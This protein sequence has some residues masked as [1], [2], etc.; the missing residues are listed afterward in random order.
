[1]ENKYQHWFQF[2]YWRWW[3]REPL[4]LLGL[5]VMAHAITYLETITWY[6]SREVSRSEVS[7]SEVSRFMS[8]IVRADQT[9]AIQFPDFC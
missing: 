2:L 6:Q 3:L 5:Q 4:I 1:M 9:L 8:K 7:R